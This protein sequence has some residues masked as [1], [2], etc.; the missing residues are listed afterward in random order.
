MGYVGLPQQFQQKEAKEDDIFTR[1][2]VTEKLTAQQIL[3]EHSRYAADTNRKRF[4]GTTLGF[5]TPWNGH[6]YDV[7]KVGLQK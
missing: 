2:L 1:G 7:A 4:N 6:G 5:V 3:S